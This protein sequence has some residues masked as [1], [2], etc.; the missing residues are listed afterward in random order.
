[1]LLFGVAYFLIGRVFAV[2]ANHVRA[3]RFAAWV[4]SGA[5]Y[6]A[7]IGYEHL[8]LRHPPRLM[9]SHA[10]LAV[11]LGAF[12]LAVAGMLHSLSTGSAIRPSWLL[13]LVLW[14]AITAI[15]AFLVAFVTGTL[16]TQLPRH[17]AT[18]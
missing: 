8:R 15:P 9:A 17:A 5:V 12:A 14:P 16:L 13:A 1:M 6:A 3:W 4:V 7:H 18:D 10:A 2:P 11:A